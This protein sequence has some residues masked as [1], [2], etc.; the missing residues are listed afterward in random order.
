MIISRHLAVYALDTLD[1]FV[2]EPNCAFRMLLVNQH[3]SHKYYGSPTKLS[4]LW[5]DNTK[6]V[7]QEAIRQITHNIAVDFFMRIMPQCVSTRWASVHVVEE[8][9]INSGID[10]ARSVMTRILRP[11]EKTGSKAQ[12]KCDGVDEISMEENSQYSEKQ[13]RWKT[14]GRTA[15]SSKRF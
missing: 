7:F 6:D 3:P 12:R 2:S 9:Y 13:S 10:R 1:V 11:K 4:H 15:L 5:R 8:R 14:E